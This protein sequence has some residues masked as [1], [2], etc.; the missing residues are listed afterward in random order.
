MGARK[1]H[2][3]EMDLCHTLA[4]YASANDCHIN[5]ILYIFSR[6]S[7][8][9]AASPILCRVEYY[10]DGHIRKPENGRKINDLF[11]INDKTAST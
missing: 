8:S 11:A 3:A 1:F 7:M 4:V 10:W 9:T 6:I 2:T 5:K